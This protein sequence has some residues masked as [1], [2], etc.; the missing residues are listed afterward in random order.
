MPGRVQPL[1]QGEVFRMVLILPGIPAVLLGLLFWGFIY[2]VA[3]VPPP[4]TQPFDFFG[5][6]M[7]SQVFFRMVAVALGILPPLLFISQS[8]FMSRKAFGRCL[9]CRKQR[10]LQ[11]VERLSTVRRCGG[12]FHELSP[13]PAEQQA[14]VFQKR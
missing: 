11:E 14:A 4:N 3:S 13:A 1:S 7:S 8:Y 6:R 12:C 9:D 5:Y 10:V 2:T